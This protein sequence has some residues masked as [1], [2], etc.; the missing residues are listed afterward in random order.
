MKNNG[1]YDSDE[2]VKVLPLCGRYFFWLTAREVNSLSDSE[3]KVSYSVIGMWSVKIFLTSES[4]EPG[5][6]DSKIW[7]IWMI[8][9]N[10]LNDGTF[11][12]VL[13]LFFFLL[14]QITKKS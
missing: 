2:G 5:L 1:E 7:C 4:V 10:C 3:P 12:F 8:L 9:D 13:E 11:D 14:S 6:S